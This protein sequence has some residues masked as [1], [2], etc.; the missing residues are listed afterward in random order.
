MTEQRVEEGAGGTILFDAAR[1]PQVDADWFS[2]QYWRERDALRS[3]PGGRGGVAIIDTPA[4]EAVLRHYRRGGM[5]ARLLGDRYLFTGARRT[6]SARE[7]RLLV[8]LCRRGLPVPPPLA[9]RFVRHGMR[10]SAD[11]ITARIPDAATLAERL[12][13][14]AFNAA[15]A[16]RVGELV[17]RF[18]REGAWHA[19][20]NAHNV[21]VNDSGL[22]L[23]DFDRG[24]LRTPAARWRHANLARLKRS[25]IKLGARDAAGDTFDAEWWPALMEQYERSLHA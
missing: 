24:R 3:Q 20:L 25:L 6:R 1:I 21:L 16:R 23:I 7:F 2:P 10:Y 19:D 9:S 11:L 5:V 15:L 17:A 4:G 14:G 12:A 8:E 22:Y 18:H 13:D